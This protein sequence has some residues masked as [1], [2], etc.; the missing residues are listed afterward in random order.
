MSL[1]INTNTAAINAH[2]NLQKN[3]EAMNKTLEKLS[4]GL[5]INR[6][7]EGPAALVISEQMRG[8]IA[9]LNQAMDNSETGISMIQTT[10]A[11]LTEVNRLLVSMRQLAVHAANEG[12]NDETMLQADQ[13]EMDNALATISR[14]SNQAQ[15]G[16]K[17]LLDGS[18][19]ASGTTTGTDLEF[20]TAGLKT[21]DARETGFEVKIIQ[22]ASKA[23]ITGTV[24]LS[25]ELIKKG[26]TL[27]VIENGKMATYSTTQDD[28]LDTAIKNFTNEV[29]RNGLAVDVM[30]DEA[31]VIHIEHE[32][33]GSEY[34]F[35]FSS[36]TAGVLS[37]QA[38]QIEVS[39]VGQDVK[40]TINGE[41]AIG[42]GQTLTGITGAANVDGLAVRFLGQA[43]LAA[44]PEGEVVGKAFVSQ[45]SVNFHVGA[46]YGQTVG[47]S[48][49]STDV[50]TL[51]KN[52][53][54]DSG[55]TSLSDLDVR[56]FQGAEDA[57]KLLDAAIVDVSARRGHLGAFQ[58]NTLESN[59]QNLRVATES[60]ASS[61]SIIRD[62]DMAKEMAN[63]TKNQ[64]MTQ[65][66][67]AM[68][69]QAN[70]TPQS[71]LKLLQ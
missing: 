44:N 7:A 9:G 15:F 66:A 30:A 4:S 25:D 39:N 36:S 11:N 47:L 1:R 12:A 61:E 60:L 23:N 33:F 50:N 21:A 40:G 29:R 69:A 53:S 45:N 49:G 51:G 32:E 34:G 38:G 70:Q 35:Q 27:T 28:T 46:N 3:D 10:E 18:L 13:D 59:L 17:K 58:K 71:V 16:N 22:N 2:R 55:Y 31:G 19:A 43:D 68:L 48:I 52:I 14:I 57:L 24:G 37:Q 8:Q 64:I 6:A 42:N 20:V 65:S 56:T 63:F 5:K 54:N 62:V 41:S 26:E 67:T